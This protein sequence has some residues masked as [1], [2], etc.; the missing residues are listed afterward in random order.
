[1]AVLSVLGGSVL[2]VQ[3][4]GPVVGSLTAVR[5]ALMNP[6]PG[7][8]RYVPARVG[9]D[10]RDGSG[11]RTHRRGFA[12]ITFRDRSILRVNERTDLVVHDGASLRRVAL[13]SGT[14]WMRVSKGVRTAVQTPV[15]TATA[16]GTEFIVG[17]NGLLKVIEGEVELEGK[18]VIIVV[19][20]GQAAMIGLG[21]LPGLA[22]AGS[23]LPGVGGQGVPPGWYNSQGQYFGSGVGSGTPA[24]NAATSGGTIGSGFVAGAVLVTT[25]QPKGQ[26]PVPEPATAA[27]LS[28]GILLLTRRLRKRGSTR[29]R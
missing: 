6:T 8:D 19:G 11:I 17:S 2:G 24:E 21:G 4:A 1:M 29:P 25:I 23:A 12:E 13:A 7:A 3:A 18:G 16:R 20:A 10:V 15:G 9:D 27:A 14:L 22:G 5:A 28:A 26:P